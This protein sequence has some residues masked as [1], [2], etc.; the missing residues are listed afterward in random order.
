MS[1]RLTTE[2]LHLN[3]P[4]GTQNRMS[5]TL[6]LVWKHC[7]DLFQSFAVLSLAGIAT[8]LLT[9]WLMRDSL[10][11]D[12]SKHYWLSIS[13]VG[14]FSC[15]FALVACFVSFVTEHESR[16]REFLTN[17]PISSF[18][19]GC[20]KQSGAALAVAV[21]FGVQL[22]AR[23]VVL[24]LCQ[25]VFE[26]QAWPVDIQ[27]PNPH[28]F[29]AMIV[30]MVFVSCLISCSFWSTSWASIFIALPLA[31]FLCIAGV[32]Y[33]SSLSMMPNWGYPR[34]SKVFLALSLI[35]A[36]AFPL[37][38]LRRRP[39]RWKRTAP[40]DP[41]DHHEDDF[42]WSSLPGRMGIPTPAW[43]AMPG[44]DRFPALCWQSVRQQ[45]MLPFLALLAVALL[46]WLFGLVIELNNVNPLNRR[47]MEPMHIGLVFVMSIT[48]YG[49]GW[50][51]LY[52]DKLNSN[53]NF[54][55]QHKEYGRELLLA[56]VLFPALL[57]LTTLVVGS[58]VIYLYI[59][60]QANM[61]PPLLS[62]LGAFSVTLMWSMALRS[63]VYTLGIG[64]LLSLT[65]NGFIASWLM[66]GGLERG[67]TMVL[68]FLWLAT[69]FA[70]APTWLS[71]RRSARWMVWFTFVSIIMFAVPLWG[72]A[73]WMMVGEL[74]V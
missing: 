5:P 31:W 6:A 38:W 59:G 53:L 13:I 27:G 71:G 18:H 65:I 17:L 63:F 68:P 44:R 40:S 54:F 4:I 3:G 74:N 62:G 25:N 60:H 20:V 26:L 48:G 9:A 16:T 36:V 21:F 19:V 8:L 11:R 51:A 10:V 32:S 34:V 1:S 67:W 73:C 45:G 50:I 57:S 42:F 30:T 72:I 66:H 2:G 29:V 37:F 22:L 58:G 70:Y 28:F 43:L 23:L 49:F 7:A 61:W 14:L 33:G 52:R 12:P 56:R 39:L 15:G 41:L 46:A 69:C 64:L 47:V 24:W 35:G 55:Q